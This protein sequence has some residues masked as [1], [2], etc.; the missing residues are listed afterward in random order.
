[1]RGLK[2]CAFEDKIDF[3]AAKIAFLCPGTPLFLRP[4]FR[5]LPDRSGVCIFARK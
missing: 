5:M 1:M 4:L 3:H 2:K